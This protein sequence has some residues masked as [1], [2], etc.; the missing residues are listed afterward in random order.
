M[1][2]TSKQF[3]VLVVLVLGVEGAA[4]ALLTPKIPPPVV[5]PACLKSVTI[6]EPEH[7]AFYQTDAGESISFAMPDHTSSHCMEWSK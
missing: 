3:V 6:F 4:L 7:Q 5:E 1:A 2:L